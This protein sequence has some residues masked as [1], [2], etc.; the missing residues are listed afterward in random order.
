MSRIALPT[1]TSIFLLAG[2]VFTLLPLLATIR[3]P[4][5]TVRLPSNSPTGRIASSA[6]GPLSSQPLM[7]VGL[8]HLVEPPHEVYSTLFDGDVDRANTKRSSS[9]QIKERA[10]RDPSSSSVDISD[11]ELE[12][13]EEYRALRKAGLTP[14]LALE[15]SRIAWVAHQARN[16]DDVG[17]RIVRIGAM[18]ACVEVEGMNA[19]MLLTTY[20]GE[21]RYIPHP[22]RKRATTAESLGVRFACSRC[23]RQMVKVS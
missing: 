7:T 23:H 14:R 21:L 2:L 22:Q 16:E 12:Q 8:P 18:N 5:L 6:L 3:V 1:L 4:I 17:G 9:R 15:R 19:C 20:N 10:G 13:S 11:E